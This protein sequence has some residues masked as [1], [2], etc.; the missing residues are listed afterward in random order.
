MGSILPNSTAILFFVCLA[1]TAIGAPPAFSERMGCP[2][3]LSPSTRLDRF[4]GSAAIRFGRSTEVTALA[5]AMAEESKI[6]I[7]AYFKGIS[8]TIEI[9][10]LSGQIHIRI[11][12][13]QL[14]SDANT[15]ELIKIGEHSDG[16]NTQFAKFLTGLLT[17]ANRIADASRE[18]ARIKFS[19]QVL[20]ERLAFIL[21]EFGFQTPIFG[22]DL[23][24]DEIAYI[25]TEKR[26][27]PSLR[28]HL[29]ALAAANPNWGLDLDTPAKLG[30]AIPFELELPLTPPTP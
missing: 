8:G 6:E 29:E 9:E 17:G 26:F 23:T 4:L 19:A 25:L 21:S 1:K 28:P 13:V 2:R 30:L 22:R 15:G 18:V 5:R 14:V 20:N 16:L 3:I 27:P 12:S 7:G 10:K 24:R 11:P